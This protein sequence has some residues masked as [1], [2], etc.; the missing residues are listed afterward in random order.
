M[1]YQIEIRY[2]LLVKIKKEEKNV[3]RH[4]RRAVLIS[5]NYIDLIE[6]RHAYSEVTRARWNV[7]DISSYGRR[8][9]WM[10]PAQDERFP[11]G[12]RGFA[13]ASTAGARRRSRSSGLRHIFSR[14]RWAGLRKDTARVPVEFGTIVTAWSSESAVWYCSVSSTGR[15]RSRRRRTVALPEPRSLARVV[16]RADE[17][18]V[19]RAPCTGRTKNVCDAHLLRRGGP[20]RPDGRRARSNQ[21]RARVAHESSARCA[22][23]R[24]SKDAS[25]TTSPARE[26]FRFANCVV[27]VRPQRF[28]RRFHDE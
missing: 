16:G 6:W 13:N 2:R 9:R 1:A 18:P 11:R 28:V 19:S 25:W 7:F 3:E 22:Q 21:T 26:F 23:P 24:D 12:F 27:R 14:R 8:V 4:L 5:M 10:W 17:I 20:W 15:L